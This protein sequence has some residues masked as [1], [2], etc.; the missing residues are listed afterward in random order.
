MRPQMREV[1]VTSV[2][3]TNSCDAW[4]LCFD[5]SHKHHDDKTWKLWGAFQWGSV[6]EEALWMWTRVWER[7]LC[8]KQAQRGWAQGVFTSK[9]LYSILKKTLMKA[10]PISYCRRTQYKDT[11]FVQQKTPCN[12]FLFRLWAYFSLLTCYCCSELW[13]LLQ[14]IYFY[15]RTIYTIKSIVWYRAFTVGCQ[16]SQWQGEHFLL[17]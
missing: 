14:S 12:T 2:W 16:L 3:Q 1:Q 13:V 6:W 7:F 9:R 8:W 17:G 4:R 5:L 10:I 11:I 15:S